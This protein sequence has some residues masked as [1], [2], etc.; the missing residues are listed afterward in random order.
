MSLCRHIPV[1]ALNFV[2]EN[3][4]SDVHVINGRIWHSFTVRGRHRCYSECM[5]DEDCVTVAYS[6][7]TEVCQFYKYNLQDYVQNTIPQ[8]NT[9][10]FRGR[11]LIKFT[12]SI[13]YMEDCC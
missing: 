9:V 6:L 3:S 10:F 11:S 13:T 7:T 8:D 5:Y 2:Q 1:K 4:I 12:R